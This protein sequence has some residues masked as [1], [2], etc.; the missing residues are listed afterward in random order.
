MYIQMEGIPNY[1]TQIYPR[2]EHA[3][4][5]EID[6]EDLDT[7]NLHAHLLSPTARHSLL[8]DQHPR[9]LDREPDLDASILL[10]SLHHLAPNVA[11]FFAPKSISD[12]NLVFRLINDVN[13]HKEEQSYIT[14]SY[15]W[16]KV[17]HEVPRKEESMPGDLPFGWVKTVEKFPLPVSSQM[18]EAVLRER[19]QGEGL[20]FDQVCINQEDEAE[21]ATA[22]GAMDSIYRNARTVVIALDDIYVK[23]DE[24]E[25]LRQYLDHYSSSDLPANQQPNRGLSPPF[26]QQQTL[27]LS[28]FERVLSSIWFER[29]WCAYEMRMGHSHVFLVPCVSDDDDEIFTFIRFT[30]AFFL[31]MLILAAE[32]P[33]LNSTH[34]ARLQ[35]LLE[36]FIR[37]SILDERRAITLQ[38][39]SAKFPQLPET[40]SFVPL[41]AE[42]F[43]QKAGGNPRLPEYLRRLDAN[44]DR[45]SIALNSAGIPLTLIP[46]SPLQRPS[47]ED[48]CIRQLLLIGLAAR[49]PV[50][51]CTAGTPLQL[52][53]G[54]NSW[55]CRPTSL[56]VPRGVQSLPRFADSGTPITQGSDGRAEYVQLD[57]IFLDLP[58]RSQRNPMFPT[59]I[60]RA[61]A[62]V[63]LCI[64]YQLPCSSGIWNT[65]QGVG[66][67]NARAEGLKNVF[68]QTLACLFDCGA[69]W[70]L[71]VSTSLQPS[72]QPHSPAQQQGLTIQMIEILCSPQLIIE[73]YIRMSEG[74]QAFTLLLDL[75]ATLITR[76]IPWA[77]GATELTH[78]PLIIS[79]PTQNIS[80]SSSSSPIYTTA[81]SSSPIYPL[82]QPL[83]PVFSPISPTLISPSKALIFAPYAHSKTLLVAVPD[84][85]TSSSYAELARAWI[86][87]PVSGYTSSPRQ[88]VSWTLQGKS[89][90][91]GGGT[92]SAGLE[93]VSEKRCHRVFGAG[94]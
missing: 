53:D 47:I 66:A 86:L 69:Q 32:L 79:L 28:F 77:S 24:A 55:L 38:N 25:F 39:P 10:Q 68:A 63:E 73:N 52:H 83:Q 23:E 91:F 5:L 9:T 1:H 71:D 94:S 4:F 58:H 46:S 22:I 51:L 54:S 80:A 41:I 49:D 19:E 7:S 8:S 11:K 59:H 48:E 57:L 26:M 44:R 6:E 42:T 92:F 34:Q 12:E 20:W 29:A 62:V 27:F 64:Q 72:A 85:V 87:V 60:Q 21:K 88:M 37:Q 35:T 61:R 43:K 50:T 13:V 15:C 78:G 31:H 3:E 18:F 74:H 93:G 81:L 70:L 65:W 33:S 75:L 17:N 2:F 82:Q 84:A 36:F 76:G 45:I 14:L 67:G 16:K 30:G 40:T 90:V 56:D 89:V